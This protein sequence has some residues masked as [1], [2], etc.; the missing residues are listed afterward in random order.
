MTTQSIKKNIV[1][2]EK[3]SALAFVEALEK[4]ESIASK[5]VSRDF[6]VKEIQG[7]NNIKAFLGEKV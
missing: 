2:D 6:S 5:S 3:D 1:I 7:V 4:A